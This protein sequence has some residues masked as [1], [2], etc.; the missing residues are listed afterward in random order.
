MTC[1]TCNGAKKVRIIDVWE[2]RRRFDKGDTK[3]K[4][5]EL[6]QEAFGCP[7]CCPGDFWGWIE[8]R[9]DKNGQPFTDG[10]IASASPWTAPGVGMVVV[11]ST[12][13]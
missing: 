9:V 1:T 13:P 12:K 4:L 8:A 5:A 7:E 2:S 6:L 3:W 11:L 10:P